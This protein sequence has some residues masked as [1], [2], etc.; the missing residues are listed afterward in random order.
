[1]RASPSVAAEMSVVP[2]PASTLPVS[3]S[4]RVDMR[5]F[6]AWNAELNASAAVDPA[7]M[8]G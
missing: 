2:T 5:A 1:M 4:L 6:M 8:A 3:G 7:V